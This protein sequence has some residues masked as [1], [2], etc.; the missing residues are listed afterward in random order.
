MFNTIEEAVS[1]IK[2][3]KMVIVVDDESRENEGDLVMAA[4]KCRAEDLNYMITKAK[5]LVCVPV[6][7]EQADNLAL[8]PMTSENTEAQGTAFSVSVDKLVGTTTGISAAERA[9]TARALANP[10]SKPADFRR[11]GHIFPLIAR[12]GGV[13]QRAGHTEAAVDLARIA[14]LNPAGTIC[15]IIQSDGTMARLPQLTEFAE[16]EGL[17]IISV[18][19]LIHWRALRENFVKEEASARLSTRWGSF[20]CRAYTDPYGPDPSLVYIALIKGDISGPE[21]VLTRV[22]SECFTGNLLGSLDCD[23]C[24]KLHEAMIMIEKE[25]RGILVYIRRG[26]GRD[27]ILANLKAAGNGEHGSGANTSSAMREY[28]TGAQ[29]LSRLGV[30]KMRL[31]TNTPAKIK[32]L[33]GWGLEITEHVPLLTHPIA[34]VAFSAALHSA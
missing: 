7:R 15:E 34:D 23:C 1:D 19:E 12:P 2:K 9:K 20:E 3:G 4:D 24:D 5:G 8:V 18:E 6:S 32:G 13:L 31:I 16:R 25:G 11:P 29:I 27:E 17:K 22:H 21:P 33:A 30:H 26:L 28:G 14:G 10:D